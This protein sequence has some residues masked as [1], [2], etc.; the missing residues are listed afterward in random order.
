MVLQLTVA[1]DST[2][3]TA[4]FAKVILEFS[5]VLA[6]SAVHIRDALFDKT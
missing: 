3:E 6:G 4:E 5:A 2:G 1:G